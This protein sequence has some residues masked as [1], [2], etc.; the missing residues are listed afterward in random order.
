MR[1]EPWDSTGGKGGK[2]NAAICE[3]GDLVVIATDKYYYRPMLDST[4]VIVFCHD[5]LLLLMS[6]K[7][8]QLGYN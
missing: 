2:K 3:E 1:I 5:V 8:L 7:I 4:T 6:I